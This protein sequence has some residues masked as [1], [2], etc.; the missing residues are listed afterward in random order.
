VAAPGPSH[1]VPAGLVSVLYFVFA[2]L[3]KLHELCEWCTASTSWSSSACW[4][5]LRASSRR[6]LHSE[7]C[8]GPTLQAPPRERG[9]RPLRPREPRPAAGR[10]RRRRPATAPSASRRRGLVAEPWA[11]GSGVTVVV[12]AVVVVFIIWELVRPRRAPPRAPTSS[13]GLRPGRGHRG[14][15]SVSSTIGAG[16]ITDPFQ[17]ISGSPAALTGP[18]GNP[19]SSTTVPSSAPTVP[20]SAGPGDRLSRFGTFSNL[21]ITKSDSNLRTSPHPHLQLLGSSY[22]SQYLDFAAIESADRNDNPLQTPT[23]AEGTLVT[24]YDTTPY[25][26]TTGGIPSRTS[27]TATS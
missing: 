18:G 25:S 21:H 10:R 23:A 11:W 15:P 24:T 4:S 19:S 3:V 17:P 26:T 22:S 2:E 1:L 7:V 12:V 13:P 14:Q 6:G 16:G 5:R 9:R 20:P 8:N 27:A